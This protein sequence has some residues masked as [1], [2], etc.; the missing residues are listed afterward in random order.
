MAVMAV[1]L[2]IHGRGGHWEGYLENVLGILQGFS[3]AFDVVE[4]NM[5]KN[6]NVSCV[7]NCLP[8]FLILSDV[9]RQEPIRLF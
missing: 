1:E 9:K 2:G 8:Y 4:M 7:F 5:C 3:N 6:V